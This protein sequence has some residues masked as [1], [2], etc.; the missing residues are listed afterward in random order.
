[1]VRDKSSDSSFFPS[2]LLL[3]GRLLGRMGR[4]DS[5]Y[6]MSF[7]FSMY[8]CSGESVSTCVGCKNHI[9]SCGDLR[10]RLTV[11]CLF[12]FAF[13]LSQFVIGV[14]NEG[15]L[16]CERGYENNETTIA[17][18]NDPVTHK[19]HFFQHSPLHN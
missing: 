12:H 13:T 6:S 5:F 7:L 10:S 16:W 19:K 9:C 1:M 4:A 8:K 18:H 17:F 2:L 14:P 15:I 11:G 3:M